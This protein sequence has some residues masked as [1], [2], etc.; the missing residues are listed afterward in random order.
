MIKIDLKVDVSGPL[1]LVQRELPRAV[2]YVQATLL[3]NLAYRVQGKVREQLPLSFDRPTPF[4]VRGVFVKQARKENLV[5]EVYFPESR[6][7][8]GTAKREYMRPG[9]LGTPNRRQK[10]TEFLLTRRGS[11]PA[12]WVTTPGTSAARHGYMDSY[13]NIKPNW[14]RWIVNALQL[15]QKAGAAKRARGIYAASERRARKMGV[16]YEAFAVAPGSKT[17]NAQGAWLPPGVYRRTGANGQ[18]LHQI[19]KFV[20]KAA[21]SPRLDV[22]SVARREVQAALQPEF[23]RAFASVRERFA[24]RS[25]TTAR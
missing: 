15:K 17:V 25:R 20:R 22:E 23:E 6:E 1:N 12:G 24:L 4:T 5:A 2:P 9:A 19:L 8:R 3:S 13:G 10:R 7:E 21:Y 18:K 16:D 11:L 14:Y